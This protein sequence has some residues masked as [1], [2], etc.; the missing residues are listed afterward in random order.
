VTASGGALLHSPFWQQMMA[1]ALGVAVTASAVPEASSRGAALLALEAQ[2]HVRSLSA[3]PAP[4]G[5]VY[6]PQR[7]NTRIYQ[8]AAARQHALYD[9]LVA[10]EQSDT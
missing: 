1:D 7:A 2:G 5:A 3:L 9:L 6:S 8:A 10:P 4:L